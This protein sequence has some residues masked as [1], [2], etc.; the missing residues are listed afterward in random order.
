MFP[1]SAFCD[2]GTKI[3]QNIQALLQ[4]ERLAPETLSIHR[5]RLTHTHT[6]KKNECSSPLTQFHGFIR[7]SSPNIHIH[8]YTKKPRYIER[9]TDREREKERQRERQKETERDR[10]R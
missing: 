10:E 1:V 5:G 2:V 9:E 7:A 3:L 6:G 4:S 8:N